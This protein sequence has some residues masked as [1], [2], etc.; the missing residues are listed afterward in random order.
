MGAATARSIAPPSLSVRALFACG[1]PLLEPFGASEGL[2]PVPAVVSAPEGFS[3]ELPAGWLPAGLSPDSPG[4]S[5][6]AEMGDVSAPPEGVVSGTSDTNVVTGPTH[7]SVVAPVT[8][9]VVS[10]QGTNV[11]EPGGQST[12]VVVVTVAVWPP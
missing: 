8:V 12:V 9:T 1:T 7:V 2:G 4:V 6:A 11:V 3:G 5:A 10:P